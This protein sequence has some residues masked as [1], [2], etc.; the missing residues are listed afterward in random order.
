MLRAAALLAA[1]VI[2]GG[3][4]ESLAEKVTVKG[5]HICCKQCVRIAEGLLKDIDGVS[6]VKADIASKTVTFEAKDKKAAETAF[7]ALIDGGFS[8][9]SSTGLKPAAGPATGASDVVVVEKV[10][11]CCGQCQ[12]AIIALFKDAKVSFE[13]P[14]PQRT[15]RIEGT[16][17]Q[18]S[19]VWATLT[20]AGFSGAIKK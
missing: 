8:G 15:V 18:H 6:E 10:H 4:R 5:P 3:A 17:L 9:T 11:V 2:L 19:A 20:K 16:G 13:G 7:K 12:K 14:G 1:L